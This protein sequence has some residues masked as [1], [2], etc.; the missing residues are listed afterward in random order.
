LLCSG[1]ELW[2]NGEHAPMGTK[3]FAFCFRGKNYLSET[4]GEKIFFMTHV[5]Q[6]LCITIA[7]LDSGSAL[8]VFYSQLMNVKNVK[9]NASNIIYVCAVEFLDSVI[10]KSM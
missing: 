9:N 6:N 8:F 1:Y 7:C 5:M 4:K 2:L 3:K 10:N